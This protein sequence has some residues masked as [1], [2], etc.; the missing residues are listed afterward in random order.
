MSSPALTFVFNP[1]RWLKWGVL[2]L[3]LLAGIAIYLADLNMITRIMAWLVVLT[4]LYT[5][6]RMNPQQ[7]IRLNADGTASMRLNGEW[8]AARVLPDSLASPWLTIMRIRPTGTRTTHSMVI[9]PDSLEADEFRKLRVWL[10]WRAT[11]AMHQET[12]ARR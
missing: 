2:V 1:S 12:H 3:H 7:T 8:Q 6:Q 5:R 4:S 11:T 10:K 9:L